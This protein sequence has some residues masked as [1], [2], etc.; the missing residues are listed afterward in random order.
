MLT[1]GIITKIGKNYG[2]ILQAFALRKALEKMGADAHIIKY[3]PKISRDSYRVCKHKWRV[4]G[5]IANLKSLFHYKE[6][7]SSTKKFL[8]FREEEFH[9]MGNYRDYSDLEKNPPICDIY[10]SGSD[11]VWNPTISFDKA[12]YYSF[13][14]NQSSKITSYAASVGL[15][16]L[17]D[18]FKEE[19]CKRV[20]RFDY[21]SVREEQARRILEGYGIEADVAPDPTFLLERSDWN[22]IAI[23]TIQ[24]PYILCY[25]V[26]YPREIDKIIQEIKEK[27]GAE[28]LVV[29]LMT[30]EESACIGDIKIRD[31]GPKEFLGLFKN[32]S[33]VVTSSFHGTAFSLINRKP[34]VT[35]PYQSTKSRVE[36]LLKKVSLEHRVIKK[37]DYD[38]DALLNEDLF[39]EDFENRLLL[40]RNVGY[41]VLEKVLK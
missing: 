21:I 26:S 32:A 16:A 1:V 4:R 20:R 41:E 22:S 31:A 6:N 33:F 14:K 11:Q 10:V 9:F 3:T 7:K 18:R 29:N 24:A 36:E 12:F 13:I 23:E 30:S 38:L 27:M 34:F 17:P 5:T 15:N 37:D 39:D 2:A 19:F 8:Q 25:F 28:Y 40:L 35:V